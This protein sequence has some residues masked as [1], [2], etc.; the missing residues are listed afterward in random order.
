MY[1]LCYGRKDVSK[2]LL[3][4]YYKSLEKAYPKCFKPLDGKPLRTPYKFRYFSL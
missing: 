1:Y 4:Q 2:H 3:D